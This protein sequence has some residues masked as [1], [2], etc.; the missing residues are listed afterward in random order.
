LVLVV[1]KGAGGGTVGVYV[2]GTRVAVVSLNA[3][4]AAA[5]VLV[6]VAVRGGLRG[7]PVSLRVEAPGRGV[8]VDGLTVR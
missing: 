8:W 2:R 1:T 4:R 3:R 5:K 6:P 7:V